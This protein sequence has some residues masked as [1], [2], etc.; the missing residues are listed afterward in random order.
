MRCYRFKPC[1]F[2]LVRQLPGGTPQAFIL[3]DG[4]RWPRVML[5]RKH[6]W[7]C[8]ARKGEWNARWWRYR[9]WP[10]VIIFD[11]VKIV[12]RRLPVTL[13]LLCINVVIIYGHRPQVWF[14]PTPDNR[15]ITDVSSPDRRQ[16]A[17]RGVSGLGLHVYTRTNALKIRLRLHIQPP[18]YSTERC[19]PSFFWVSFLSGD[20]QKVD[21]D[22]FCDRFAQF[23]LQLMFGDRLEICVWGETFS[24]QQDQQVNPPLSVCRCTLWAS[25]SIK[26]TIVYYWLYLNLHSL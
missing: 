24:L 14:L 10:F 13:L 17:G 26:Q 2:R 19:Y 22:Q 5:S 7:V 4:V 16:S 15:L 9:C 23:N 21:W 3:A 12:R 8:G 11:E 25:H 6:P 1:C 20:S 18:Q